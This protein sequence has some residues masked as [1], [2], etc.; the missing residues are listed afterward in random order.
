MPRS[1]R[2]VLPQ[3]D[4][5]PPPSHLELRSSCRCG[6][7]SFAAPAPAYADA[8]RCHCVACRKFHTSAFAAYVVL[9]ATP[10]FGASATTIAGRCAILGDVERVVCSACSSKLATR[11]LTGEDAGTTLLALGCVEDESVPAATARRWQRTYEEWSIATAATWWTAVAERG[12][13]GSNACS[14]AA[15]PAAAVASRRRAATSFRRSTATAAS[16]ASARAQPH[17]RGCRCAR[18]DGRRVITSSWCARRATASATCAP[19]A[20]A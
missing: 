9:A 20:T 6:R 7:C 1:F 8:I 5:A 18:C 4:G 3:T 11:P 15:A 17:K 13:G 10:D 2:S 16:A 12:G 19:G 14:A